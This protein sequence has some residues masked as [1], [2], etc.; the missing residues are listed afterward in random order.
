M[1]FTAG[2]RAISTSESIRIKKTGRGNHDPMVMT[3]NF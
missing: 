2:P 3:R 1:I